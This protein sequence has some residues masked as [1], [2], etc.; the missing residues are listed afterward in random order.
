M[1]VRRRASERAAETPIGG[2][3]RRGCSRRGCRATRCRSKWKSTRTSMKTSCW[4]HWSRRRTSCFRSSALLQRRP[5]GR[6][7]MQT[8]GLQPSRARR[9]PAIE[10]FVA[11]NL[12]RAASARTDDWTIRAGPLP[13]EAS[14]PSE[15]VRSHLDR[16][17]Q[18]RWT[19]AHDAVVARLH[20][21]RNGHFL[22]RSRPARAPTPL[23]TV[24]TAPLDGTV[25]IPPLSRVRR[26]ATDA[27]ARRARAETRHPSCEG[28]LRPGSRWYE[29]TSIG[30]ARWPRWRAPDRRAPARLAPPR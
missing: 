23:E 3:S 26:R 30:D 24:R 13:N 25:G 14:A 10:G 11:S 7:R 9:R 5:S 8:R 12:L 2:R 4:R 18:Q 28:A 20:D 22:S 17:H 6:Y 1:C 19:S 16:Q 27:G 21:V 15:R 29:R